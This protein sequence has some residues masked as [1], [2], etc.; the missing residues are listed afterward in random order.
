[1]NGFFPLLQQIKECLCLALSETPAG[2]PCLCC[3]IHSDSPPSPNSSTLFDKCECGVAWVRMAGMTPVGTARVERNMDGSLCKSFQQYQL[4][5]ELGVLRCVG[6]KT[7]ISGEDLCTCLEAHALVASQ[8]QEA[9]VKAV[10]CCASAATLL[11]MNP[12]GLE[13]CAGSTLQVQMDA[14]LCID[15]DSPA[16][17]PAGGP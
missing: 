16:E 13:N 12:L 14:T 7:G 10:E 4:T 11:R 3:V 6:L 2:R 9:L 8:D 1:M 17:S 5:I 15:C